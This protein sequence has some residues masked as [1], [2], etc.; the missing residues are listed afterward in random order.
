MTA[1]YRTPLRTATAGRRVW[2]ELV[3]AAHAAGIA[4]ILDVVYN[5]YG[6]E[7][8][9]LDEFGTYFTDEYKT[10]WGRAIN[11]DQRG[12][13]PVREF[14]LDNVRMWIEE[15]HLDGLRLDAIHAIYDLGPATSFGKS[16]KPPMTSLN[17]LA[18]RF[19]SSPKAT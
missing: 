5:H 10:P 8:N 17:G 9:Y 1:S 19:T 18:G 14:V 12:S 3:D 2:P 15:F 11:F 4:V 13:N 6:P 16:A 7:G